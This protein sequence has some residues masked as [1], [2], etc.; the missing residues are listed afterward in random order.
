MVTT[1]SATERVKLWNQFNSCVDQETVKTDFIRRVHRKNPPFRFKLK[2]KPRHCAEIP[3]MVEFH[4]KNP[5]P[6]LP[7]L[8]DVLR[9]ERVYREHGLPNIVET[10]Q[11]YDELDK[12]LQEIRVAHEKVRQFEEEVCMDNETTEFQMDQTAIDESDT[13]GLPENKELSEVEVIENIV[14]NIPMEND[15]KIIEKIENFKP[16]SI[17]STDS[18]GENGANNEHIEDENSVPEIDNLN[19][20]KDS[21]LSDANKMKSNRKRKRQTSSKNFGAECDDLLELSEEVFKSKLLNGTNGNM[22]P[23]SIEDQLDGLDV[24]VIKRL[25]LAQLQQILKESPELVT[26]YQNENANKAIKDALKAKPVKMTLPSQ[27]LSKDDIAKIAEQFANNSSSDENDGSDP[28]YAG[29]THPIPPMPNTTAIYY[30]NGFENIMD[31][32][33]RALAIAQRLEKPLRESKVRA[34]AVLTPVGD[35]L[36][37]KQWY[38]N[39]HLD[40]SLFM[41]YRSL[42]IGSGSGCD[43]QMKNIRKCARL[44][45]RHATIFY[46]EVR[47]STDKQFYVPGGINLT[48]QMHYFRQQN[49]TNC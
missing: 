19:Q 16:P 42:V 6:L 44:S 8:K 45:T 4:Y 24:D 33:E 29:V 1:I 31:D 5:P 48:I 36:A 35:I 21:L 7:S 40:D 27:M 22:S 30:A 12:D 11:V 15:E 38:T 23:T 41:R 10:P 39:S 49:H 3:P 34:R 13:N 18:N 17:E 37:G 2:P 25:A 14:E 46:D 43:L 32:N 28:A 20:A 9:C 26:K 47:Y